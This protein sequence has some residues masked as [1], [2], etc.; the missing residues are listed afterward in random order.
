MSGEQM[1]AISKKLDPKRCAG[2]YIGVTKLSASAADFASLHASWLSAGILWPPSQYEAG[3]LSTA[4]SET[5]VDR[6]VS[7]FAENAVGR[8]ADSGR[9]L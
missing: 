4:H 2:E 5:D 1:R 8:R 9:G 6:T 3:F 7:C